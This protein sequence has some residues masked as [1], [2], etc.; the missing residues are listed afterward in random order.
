MPYITFMW[1]PKQDVDRVFLIK[2]DLRNIADAHDVG[3][4]VNAKEDEE[5][6]PVV[7]RDDVTLPPKVIERLRALATKSGVTIYV[8]PPEP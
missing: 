4:Y 7:L 1:H 6:E 2:D 3:F 5:T 8:H